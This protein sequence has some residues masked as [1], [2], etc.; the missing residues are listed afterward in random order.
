MF[1]KEVAEGVKMKCYKSTY[2]PFYPRC[3]RRLYN[4]SY[5]E[6]D[7]GYGICHKVEGEL[8]KG[9]NGLHAYKSIEEASIFN[10]E[11]IPRE[12]RII[13]KAEGGEEYLEGDIS[14]CFRELKTIRQVPPATRRE[15]ENYMRNPDNWEKVENFW[16]IVYLDNIL[17]KSF[18]KEFS[19]EILRCANKNYSGTDKYTLELLLKYKN[20][21]E[22][23]KLACYRLESPKPS[24][25]K[26]TVEELLN[27]DKAINNKN[28]KALNKVR[29][30]VKRAYNYL[31]EII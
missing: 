2:A 11:L 10:L 13:W 27:L 12:K 15:I 24:I 19:K 25:E 5:K 14:Y 28:K 29:E 30:L 20:E 6:L 31:Q 3:N 1:D 7:W 22:R 26:R 17:S 21:P 16:F 9:A 4:D 18:I 23:V 8:K